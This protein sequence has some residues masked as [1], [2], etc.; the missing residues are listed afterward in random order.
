VDVRQGT[1]VHAIGDDLVVK[2]QDG[3][4][5]HFVIPSDQR[6]DID[7]NQVRTGDLKP[8]TRLMQTIV[9]TTKDVTVSSVRNVDLKV[10]QVLSSHVNVQLSDGTQK[11]LKVPDGTT[12]EI[13]GKQM[14]L[15]DLREGMRIKG[16]VITKTPATVVTQA[17]STAGVAPVEIPTLIGVVLIDE[18]Q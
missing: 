1:V 3:S 10:V 7:G 12:F 15:A 5:K 8:G 9:T 6:F 18:K 11:L 4:V 13:D 17:K 2:M 14:K 16:T